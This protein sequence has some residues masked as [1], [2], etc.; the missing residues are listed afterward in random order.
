MLILPQTF[1]EKKNWTESDETKYRF[2]SYSHKD[3]DSVF[4]VLKQ[5]SQYKGDN[6]QLGMLI[7]H[8]KD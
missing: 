1:L 7:I 8:K 3:R 5:L 6:S 2:I 4:M